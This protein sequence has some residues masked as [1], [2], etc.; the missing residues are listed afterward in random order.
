MDKSSNMTI[1]TVYPMYNATQ[2]PQL[3]PIVEPA[4]NLSGLKYVSG[5]TLHSSITVDVIWG[6]DNDGYL[7]KLVQNGS[8]WIPDTTSAFAC[9]CLYVSVLALAPVCGMRSLY[10]WHGPE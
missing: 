8:S 5:S 10:V 3:K 1:T 2:P 6:A 4:P 7:Q 9:T